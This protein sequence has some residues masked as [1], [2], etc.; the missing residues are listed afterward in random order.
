MS[1]SSVG[2]VFALVSAALAGGAAAMLLQH[3]KHSDE[4]RRHCPDS[5][6]R[7]SN[8]DTQSSPAAGPRPHGFDDSNVVSEGGHSGDTFL[9]RLTS[10]GLP[11][12]DR[13]R[14]FM[15]FVASLNYER[16][17]PNWVLEHLPGIGPEGATYRM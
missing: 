9:E 15:G 10:K 16:R 13:V 3:G 7:R 8:G 14:Y 1:A 6:M 5:A 12:H 11:S 17:I 2:R 4:G